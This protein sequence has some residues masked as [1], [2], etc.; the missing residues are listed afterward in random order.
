[1][2]FIKKCQGKMLIPLW[3]LCVT[4]HE[5][6]LIYIHKPMMPSLLCTP[7]VELRKMLN[8]GISFWHHYNEYYIYWRT[9]Y[10]YVR[11]YTHHV[12][13]KY[14]SLYLPSVKR[15]KEKIADRWP[16]SVYFWILHIC[17]TEL[18]I[19]NNQYILIIVLLGKHVGW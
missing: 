11:V 4:Q 10:M 12:P 13:P 6:V 7:I 17:C 8:I 1:M 2:H 5:T 3:H 14:L 18:Y 16:C 15:E 19:Y 9:I